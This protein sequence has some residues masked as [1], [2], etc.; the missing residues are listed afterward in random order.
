[1][2]QR[3]LPRLFLLVLVVPLLGCAT[4]MK[5]GDQK[6]AFQSDPS[7]AKVS[8]YDLDDR[9]VADG[10]TPITLPLAK[11]ASYFQAAK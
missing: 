11:G 8:V 2:K 9:L 10:R 1:M 7:G 6:I 5:D 3:I 4:I